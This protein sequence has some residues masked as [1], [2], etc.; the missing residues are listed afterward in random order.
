M[1]MA[2]EMNGSLILPAHLMEAPLNAAAFEN[3]ALSETARCQQFI[4]L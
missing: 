1:N 3:N 4:H 2:Q